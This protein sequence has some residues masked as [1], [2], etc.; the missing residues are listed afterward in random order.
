MKRLDELGFVANGSGWWA[1]CCLHL[2]Q[3]DAGDYAL[4]FD[5]MLPDAETY[6]GF[7]T[8]DDALHAL[9]W[10]VPDL[11]NRFS[12][13][14]KSRPILPCNYTLE[15]MIIGDQYTTQTEHEAQIRAADGYLGRLEELCAA[16]AD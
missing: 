10:I 8:V 5:F 2:H 14:P 9:L 15:D 7:H 11:R 16:I 13:L 6:S 1:A 3:C 4:T 12:R